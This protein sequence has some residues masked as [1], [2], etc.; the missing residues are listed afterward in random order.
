[1]RFKRPILKE[2]GWVLWPLGVLGVAA[3]DPAWR[4]ASL[5]LA[6]GVLLIALATSLEG[7]ASVDALH[8][9]GIAI[10]HP[11]QFN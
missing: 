9:I 7:C 11:E 4:Q 5:W 10:V 8:T 2:N 6:I 3:L 1:M